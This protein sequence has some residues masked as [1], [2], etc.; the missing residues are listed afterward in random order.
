VR[1]GRIASDL[2]LRLEVRSRP[3]AAQT[4]A[5]DARDAVEV[6]VALVGNRASSTQ[7]TFRSGVKP[8]SREREDR[9]IGD[10]ALSARRLDER[11]RSTMFMTGL[12]QWSVQTE[13][14]AQK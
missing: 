9:K 6:V 10:R 2:R 1:P 3:Q 4:V 12:G 14:R 5:A 13:N 7:S 8:Q 11:G